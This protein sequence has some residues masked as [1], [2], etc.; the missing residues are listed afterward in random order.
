MKTVASTTVAGKTASPLY[1][2][3]I[4]GITGL[5]ALL[6]PQVLFF[7]TNDEQVYAVQHIQDLTLTQEIS[8]AMVAYYEQTVLVPRLSRLGGRHAA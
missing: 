4:G 8:P 6:H 2:A 5:A 1:H 3:S 7:P